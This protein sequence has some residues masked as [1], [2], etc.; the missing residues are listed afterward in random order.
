M[1]VPPSITVYGQQYKIVFKKSVDIN[2]IQC[3]GLCDSRNHIIY[4]DEALKKNPAFLREV[5]IHEMG[6]ALLDRLGF[7]LIGFSP[8]LEELFVQAFAVLMNENFDVKFKAKRA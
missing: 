5:I 7:H 6:H 2:G 1:K 8:E 4:L 3:E